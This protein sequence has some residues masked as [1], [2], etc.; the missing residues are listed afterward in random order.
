MGRFG[1]LD[2]YGFDEDINIYNRYFLGGLYNLR[3]YEFRTIGPYT[4]DGQYPIGGR[5]LW[6]ASA[7]YSVPIIE[8]LRIAAFYDIG[9][10]YPLAYSF[11]QQGPEY[12]PYTDDFGFGIRLNIPGM[13]PL[14]LD[15]AIPLKHDPFVDGK[16]RFQ[17]SVGYTRDY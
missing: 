7:E 14:R 17:F 1:I 16:G 11:Q 15:Y 3:G 13:G 12:G 4:A 9:N 2:T 8:R 10:V 6:F 5:T